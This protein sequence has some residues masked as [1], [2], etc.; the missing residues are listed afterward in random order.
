MSKEKKASQKV[1]TKA[2]NESGPSFFSFLLSKE[3]WVNLGLFFG[4][5]L[6]IFIFLK[7]Y[8]PYPATETDSG[9][10]ILSAINGKIN[11]YRPMGYSSFL[12][13]FGT[14]SNDIQFVVTWQWFVTM[15]CSFFFVFTLHY[16]YRLKNYLLWALIVLLSLNPSAIFLNAYLMSDGLFINLTLAF[17]AAGLWVAYRKSY[18]MLALHLFLLYLS[19]HTRYI[20][21]FYPAISILFIVIGFLPKWKIGLALSVL[22]IAIVLL[23]RNSVTGQMEEEFGVKTFSAFGGWQKANNG[24]AI[25]PFEKIDTSK[26]TD[27]EVKYVHQIVRQFPDS[28]FSTEQVMATS[29]MWVKEFPGKAVLFNYIQQTNT[30]YLKSWA[31]VGT[32]ME[33]Y[34]DFLQSNYRGAYFSHFILP[35]VKNIVKVYDIDEKA[36][37]GTDQNTKTFFATDVDKYTFKKQWFKP[38]TAIRQIAEYLLWL[39]FIL[40]LAGMAKIALD[41]KLSVQERL[42]ILTVPAF[43]VAFCLASAYAAPINN[44]RYMMPI[45]GSQL[46]LIFVVANYFLAKKPN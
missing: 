27:N 32:M 34:G 19:M 5:H 16:I 45:Y 14:F 23:Y 29:F 26:M 8:Y 15:L 24:V 9:N 35:N 11:G 31:Y 20:G 46:M 13:F 1:T 42:G 10:Y 25:L 12:A 43:V 39:L 21:L 4:L 33:K 18:A 22:P 44:F 38:L 2:A 6:L 30:T 28:V 41:K 17:L 40:S 37:F 3:N 36:E 7:I